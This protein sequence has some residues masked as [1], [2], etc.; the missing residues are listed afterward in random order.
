MPRT[1]RPTVE[2][3]AIVDAAAQ[4]GNLKIKAFA[5]AGK[6]STLRLVADRFPERSG[7][8]LAFN[9]EIANQARQKFP[10]HVKSGTVHSRA[11]ASAPSALRNRMSFQT[12]P[13][14][15]LANRYRLGSVR[16]SSVLGKPVELLPFEIGQMITDGLG[17]FCRSAQARPETTHIPVDE[18]I[19]GDA[20]SAIREWLLPYVVRLWGESID[21]KACSAVPP[22][23]LLKV[24]AQAKPHI[25]ADFILFDEAQDSDGVMLSILE[26][27]RHAQIVYVGDP[28]QQIYEWRG[29]INAMTQIDAPEYALT[30]SFRFG[31]TLATLASRTLQ[32]LGERTP[33]RGQDSIGSILVEDPRITPPV[34]AVLCRKNVT[35]IWQFAAGL[36]SGHT[37]SIRMSSAEIEAY[38]NGADQLLAG[39]RVFRPAVFSLF[40]TWKDV[41]S[42]A[43]SVVGSDLLPIVQIV[44][45]H[46]TDYLRALAQRIA[47]ETTA[48]YVVSTIHRAK[49][50][51]WK[52]VRVAND[53]RFQ[54]IDGR[55]ALDDDE[56][57][58]L[59]VALTRAQHLLDVSALRDELVRLITQPPHHVR[60]ATG[61]V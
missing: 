8:Y 33:L 58:L 53:F 34:D 61:S 38:A 41:Q 40:E 26:R 46:G 57:R 17:R 54:M 2:Q 42:F 48:D 10:S 52:R 25:D 35:A 18:K 23:V 20:A 9:R 28:H 24:W 5:G 37:P 39:R 1:F 36:E 55:L 11:Y 30:E 12:E 14:H 32:L 60:G 27:Q 56:K 47:P 19:S 29:A 7:V 4:G 44:D 21:P 43:R 22:D 3:L 6:T 49:G 13:P 51:E 15:E 59:Y 31:P 16:V 50:F 45:Q